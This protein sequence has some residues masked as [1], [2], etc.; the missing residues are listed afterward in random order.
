MTDNFFFVYRGPSSTPGRYM[1]VESV[2]TRKELKVETATTANKAN[3]SRVQ[4]DVSESECN[5]H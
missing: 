5:R 1:V 3:D 4:E 2:I